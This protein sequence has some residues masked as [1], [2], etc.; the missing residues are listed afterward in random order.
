MPATNERMQA[1]KKFVYEGKSCREI[2]DE[3]HVHANTVQAWSKEGG[4]VQ[5]RQDHQRGSSEATLDL[6][7][8][9][10]ELLVAKIA[11]DKVAPAD[12]IDTLHKLTMSIEKMESRMEAVGPML[13]VIGRFARYVAANSERD[14]CLV[15]RKWIEKYLNAEQRKSG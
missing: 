6:L 3:L 4:W 12:K 14:E 2:G 8:N 5:R 9:Q 11:V 1:L 13:D 10:R 7:K 15:V